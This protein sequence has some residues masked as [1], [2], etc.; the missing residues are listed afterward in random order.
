MIGGSG[1]ADRDTETNQ[2]GLRRCFLCIYLDSFF[3]ID[4]LPAEVLAYTDTCFSGGKMGT[5]LKSF[6][7]EVL[8]GPGRRPQKASVYQCFT[9]S[10]QRT[11]PARVSK[12]P[13]CTTLFI[14]IN[15]EEQK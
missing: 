3:H 13:V 15:E 5:G 6:D 9:N 1:L 14:L 2:E 4:Q 11:A 10:L 7:I 8:L 12:C